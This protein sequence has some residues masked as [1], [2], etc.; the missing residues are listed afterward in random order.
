[1]LQIIFFILICSFVGVRSANLETVSDE[2]L[3][4]LIKTEKYVVVLFSK[5]RLMFTRIFSF[6]RIKERFP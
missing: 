6:I 5:F 2:E 1:M 3:I 4:N